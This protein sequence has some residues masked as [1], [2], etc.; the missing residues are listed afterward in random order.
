MPYFD[1]S[2]IVAHYCPEKLS[3]KAEKALRA[4]RFPIISSLVEVEFAS[5]VARKVREGGLERM[6]ASR[7]MAEFRSHCSQNSFV[8]ETPAPI[9]YSLAAN[10]ISS[11]ATPLRTLD[12]IHLAIASEC[13]AEMITADRQMA[14]SAKLLKVRCRIIG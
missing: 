13:G 8:I 14:A 11:F 9:H 10:W 7:I 12:A 4:A 5:A 2:I 3:D 1:T 6:D